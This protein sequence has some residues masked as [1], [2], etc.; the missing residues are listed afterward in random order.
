[1][2]DVFVLVF[3]SFKFN[4]IVRVEKKGFFLEMWRKLKSNE[5]SK[6]LGR[7]SHEKH[8]LEDFCK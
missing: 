8:I 7:A 2:F 1:M 5:T 3:L 6:S 4:K